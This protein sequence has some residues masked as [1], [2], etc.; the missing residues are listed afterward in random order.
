MRVGYWTAPDGEEGKI[1]ILP[2]G[3]DNGEGRRGLTAAGAI[4]ALATLDGAE[5]VRQC[6]HAAALLAQL[7]AALA[8]Q[9]AD[10]PTQ[11]F[12]LGD[13]SAD[14]RR[15][16]ADVLGE[17]E[18]SGIVALPD[19]RVAQIQESVLAGLWRVQI[20][21]DVPL[22][23]VEIG[24]VP[25]IVTRAGREL[26]AD[27]V[28][29]GAAPE[30]AMNVMPVLAEIRERMAAHRP[31]TPS[32]VINFTLLPMNETDMAHLQQVLGNG[33]VQLFSRGY[34]TCRVLATGTRHVWSVQFT[35]A[36]DKV[37]LDTLEIGDV[38][39]AARA[40]DEDFE[41]SAERLSEI[42]EAYFR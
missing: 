38:P 19:G 31:G 15:L 6:P 33:P 4:S 34:G 29:I 10:A 35:N 1:T 13:L 9:R 17:G 18:V 37:I 23:T 2:V 27:D 5:L 30:G 8:A 39:A 36:M 12:T 22:D 25:E 14:E 7:A 20:E 32:H 24:A 16:V 42:I 3:H 21:G 40:A 26:T 28:T 11:S 41:D